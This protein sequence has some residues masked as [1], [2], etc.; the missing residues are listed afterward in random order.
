MPLPY[1]LVRKVILSVDILAEDHGNCNG[2][3]LSAAETRVPLRRRGEGVKATHVLSLV[4]PRSSCDSIISERRVLSRCTCPRRARRHNDEGSSR[5][6][7][8]LSCVAVT[9]LVRYLD[10]EA[11]SEGHCVARWPYRAEFGGSG[12]KEKRKMGE[13]RRGEEEEG[14]AGQ[15]NSGIG[16]RASA[17]TNKASPETAAAL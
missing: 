2:L 12:G 3:S 10:H 13:K 16:H 6:N 11:H 8:H 17:G 7:E 15:I 9:I 1:Q 4:L 5:A 14:Q